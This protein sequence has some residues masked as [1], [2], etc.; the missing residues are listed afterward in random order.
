MRYLRNF[1][2]R[3]QNWIGL[4]LVAIF[5]ATAVAAPILSPQDPSF[6]GPFK[7][8]KTNTKDDMVPPGKNAILGTMPGRFDVFHSLVWGARNALNFGLI[9]TVF[10]LFFGMLY[11]A[12]SGYAGNV[13]N[14]MMMRITDAFLSFPVIA[15]VVFLQQLLAIAIESAGGMYLS[16]FKPSRC[17]GADPIPVTKD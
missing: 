15:G 6:P 11:G 5:I 9:V 10:S 7:K 3:W 1:F 2:S 13:V 4:I 16:G 17:G 12:I 14:R 8:V